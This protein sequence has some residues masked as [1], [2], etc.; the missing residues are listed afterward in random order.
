VVLTPDGKRAVSASWGD[1]A[2]R[3]WDLA[4]GKEIHRFVLEAA[5]PTGLA[6]S[7]D[8]RRVVSGDSLGHLRL[9]RI[10]K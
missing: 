1:R 9:W 10:G 4:T 7:P 2:I 5:L 3:L 6:L 8:G